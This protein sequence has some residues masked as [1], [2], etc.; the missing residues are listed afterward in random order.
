L[1]KD[2]DGNSLPYKFRINGILMHKTGAS[3]AGTSQDPVFSLI[4]VSRGHLAALLGK[5]PDSC[6]EVVIWDRGGGNA[7]RIRRLARESHCHFFYSER[8]FGV[9]TPVAGVASDNRL[10]CY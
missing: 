7:P 5:D 6:T 1:L 9:T 3:L 8:W 10:F 4:F 2:V